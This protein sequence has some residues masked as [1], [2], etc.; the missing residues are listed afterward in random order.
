MKLF[1]SCSAATLLSHLKGFSQRS[2]GLLVELV[3]E[4]PALRL[5]QFEEPMVQV[6]LHLGSGAWL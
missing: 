2:H 6:A 5:H 4:G 1:M 3:E